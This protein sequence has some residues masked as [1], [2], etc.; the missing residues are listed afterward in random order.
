MCAVKCSL[1]AINLVKNNND[2]DVEGIVKVLATSK[3]KI[4]VKE[5]TVTNIDAP[6]FLEG[7]V[8]FITKNRVELA[9]ILSHKEAAS[10]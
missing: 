6:G 10:R 7:Y 5:I 3:S 4:N 8:A 2:L 1:K 9:T